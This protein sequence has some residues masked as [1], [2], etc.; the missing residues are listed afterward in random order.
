MTSE[1]QSTIKPDFPWNDSKLV[2]SVYN[3]DKNYKIIETK[4]KTGKIIVFFSSNAIYY[5]NDEETFTKR[6][7]EE[8]YYDWTNISKHKLIQKNF[9]KIVFVRDVYKQ[10]YVK[11]INKNINDID[12]L[13][14]LIK[15]ITKGYKVT[16]VGSSAGGYIASLVG[17]QIGAERII[18]NSGQYNLDK[19]DNP[20]PFIEKYSNDENKIK[21]YDIVPYIKKNSSRIYYFYPSA[22]EYDI[23]Q[24]SLTD[25]LT[26][27]YFAMDSTKHGEAIRPVCYP[28]IITLKKEKLGRLCSDNREDIVKENNLYKKVVPINVRCILSIKKLLKNVA[29]FFR[30]P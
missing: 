13:I 5:P 12:C 28:Y 18:N 20:G 2:D 26:M 6:I 1:T 21:Y 3:N 23:I 29:I 9:E 19:C 15:L 30:R 16:T 8:D 7:I 24:S 27:N 4:A 22:C 11:G 10:W 17:C 25:G 14:E